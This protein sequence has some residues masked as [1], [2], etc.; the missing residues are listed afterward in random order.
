MV[1]GR[2]LSETALQQ[3]ALPHIPKAPQRR[4]SS[5]TL[6]CLSSIRILKTDDK[7]TTKSRKSMRF[8]ALKKKITL[9][10]S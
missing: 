4:A 10:S 5:R 8:S 9:D 2:N 1:T 3:T 6:I 7:S